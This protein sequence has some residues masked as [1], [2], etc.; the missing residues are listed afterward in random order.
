MSTLADFASYSSS[1]PSFAKALEQALNPYEDK[2]LRV[3]FV[4]HSTYRQKE[5]TA[6]LVMRMN[7]QTVSFRQEKRITERKTQSGSTFFHWTNAKGQNNDILKA[8][9]SGQTGNINLRTGARKKGNWADALTEKINDFNDW[10]NEQ[11]DTASNNRD[12]SIGV[13]PTGVARNM[14]GPSRLANFWN[15][16]ALTVEPMLDIRDGLP[17]VKFIQFT[18]PLFGNTSIRL[19]GHF[20]RALDITDDASTP[21]NA[22]YSFGFTAVSTTP[23]V[24]AI[25]GTIVQNL[26]NLYYNEME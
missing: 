11:M 24:D 4:L 2:V 10:T 20:D 3:P 21:F 7:P 5:G 13:E 26:S 9:F 15:L 16:H 19:E 25:Y 6:P 1:V 22:N 8:E 18:S 23:S 14:S 17:N 12:A